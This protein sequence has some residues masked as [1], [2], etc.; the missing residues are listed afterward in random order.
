MN[1]KQGKCKTSS[2]FKINNT[3]VTDPAT[4][5]NKFNTFFTNIG[6]AF[7]NKITAPPNKSFTDFLKNKTNSRFRFHEISHVDVIKTITSLKSKS[8]SSHDNITSNL[9]K[10]IATPLAHPLAL[11]INQSL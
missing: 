3:S 4:I 11:I 1:R 6:P 10:R 5:S 8:S 7:A 2:F 9:I